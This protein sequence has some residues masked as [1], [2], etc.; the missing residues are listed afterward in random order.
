MA[1]ELTD[2][3]AA[4]VAAAR[5][6]EDPFLHLEINNVFPHDLYRRMLALM[7]NSG[8][9]RPMHGRS[10]TLDLANGTHTRV[11]IDLFPEHVRAF[12][13][14]KRALWGVVGAA[15]RSEPVRLAFQRRLAPA[16]A[17]RFGSDC[18]A[19]GLYPIPI[20]TRDIP[21]YLIP[22]HTDTHW[23]GITVQLYLPADEANTDIGTIFHRQG[24]DGSLERAKQ[25]RFAPNT[26]Y[27][28]AVG[29]D[30]WHSADKVHD[31]VRT[32]D[33]ILLTYFVDQGP[34][35]ML[36]NRSKRFGNFVANEIRRRR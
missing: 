11:K 8:D 24:A 21:G 29:E 12:P 19:V 22:P 15:L 9:Y 26:G 31:R 13:A 30:S 5:A 2:H 27:A 17:R 6:F 16:L 10:K 36:R 34:F 25:M 20:L 14:E 32:R 4:S 33:S 23:K 3:I 1:E 18:E 28:F 35:R 7:P